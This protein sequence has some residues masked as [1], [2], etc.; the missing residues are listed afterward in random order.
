LTGAGN[1]ATFYKSKRLFLVLVFL[2]QPLVNEESSEF[3]FLPFLTLAVIFK[4]VF[5]WLG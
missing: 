1:I 4:F 5:E 2:H 3:F